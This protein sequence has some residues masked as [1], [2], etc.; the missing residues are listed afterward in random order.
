MKL[1]KLT[2]NQLKKIGVLEDQLTSISNAS[3]KYDRAEWVKEKGHS[4]REMTRMIRRPKKVWP[5]MS[6][7]RTSTV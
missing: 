1:L 5:Y 6:T 7:V 2:A 3:Q 4:V